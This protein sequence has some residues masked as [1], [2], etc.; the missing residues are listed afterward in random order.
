MPAL[1]HFY[2]DRLGV[3]MIRTPHL[4]TPIADGK[5]HPV[6]TEADVEAVIDL[7]SS[8]EP[9]AVDVE[10]TGIGWEDTLTTVQIG[11]QTDAFVFCPH[12]LP[13]LVHALLQRGN[14]LAHNAAFDAQKLATFAGWTVDAVLR[15]MTDTAVLSRL[16]DSRSPKQG[17]LGHALKDLSVAYVDP[18]ANV[19]E[20]E[21]KD[22]FTSLGYTKNTGWAHMDMTHQVFVRYAGLDVLLTARLFSLLQTQVAQMGVGHLSEFDHHVLRIVSSMRERGFRVDTDYASAL[23][24]DLE[25]EH[26]GHRV[27][28][29][30]LGVANV[31]STRQVADALLLRGH[32]LTERTDSGEWKVDKVVLGGI[33]SDVAR[34]VLGAK[35][36]NKARKSWVEPILEAGLHDGRV[37]PTINPSNAVTY[38]MS[39][40]NPG[41]HQL[42]SDD[43]RVRSCLTADP[44]QVLISCDFSQIELR[45]VASLAREQSMIDVFAAGGDIH[46]ATAARLF[47]DDF[48]PRQRGLAKN[49][50]FGV[51]YGG[52]AA[53]L[54]RQAGISEGDARMTIDNFYRQFPGVRRWSNDVIAYIKE[55]RPC[56]VTY[57]GR[58]I[59]LSPMFAYR[60]VNY[61]VQ[62]LAGDV[63]KQSLINLD[64]AGLTDHLLLP[65]HDEVI[66]QAPKAE[67]ADVANEIANVMSDDLAGVPLTAEAE[68]IGF[69]WGDKYAPK[70]EV[71]NAN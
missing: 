71:L 66:A 20:Q 21:L 2:T 45:V 14:L 10:S 11:N 40:S 36:A 13:Q 41:L 37:H 60:A 5:V 16:V 57:T 23:A 34:A 4:D 51:I 43:H 17:G 63:F 47:G 64:R 44:G 32:D 1:L 67:A 3:P 33:D 18:N 59:N 30:A 58:Q 55:R 31:N 53:T 48:T 52:G 39:I 49:T 19:G 54:G 50:A 9:L 62:S 38:R 6:H 12:E 24:S 65:V 15:L 25:D 35:E 7:L 46:S 70:P 68:V 42:P 61:Q 29:S 27:A 56:V 22:H 28:A 8:D 69:R 26:E